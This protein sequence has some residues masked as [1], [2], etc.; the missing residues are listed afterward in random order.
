MKVGLIGRIRIVII[1]FRVVGFPDNHD[2]VVIARH[3]GSALNVLDVGVD[4][5]FVRRAHERHR[6]AK[7]V[8]TTD[9]DIGAVSLNL[10]GNPND[11]VFAGILI[12]GDLRRILTV[13]RRLIDE[14]DFRSRRVVAAVVIGGGDDLLVDIIG[15][16]LRV[17][18]LPDADVI[19]AV[20]RADGGDVEFLDGVTVDLALDLE[21][22]ALRVAV[23]VVEASVQ[24][25][26]LRVAVLRTLNPSDQDKTGFLVDRDVDVPATHTLRTGDLNLRLLSLSARIEAS[27]DAV[28]SFVAFAD[29]R[30]HE[31]S[32]LGK[33]NIGSHLV[34][35]GVRIDAHFDALLATVGVKLMHN[36]IGFDSIQSTVDHN[37]LI[38]AVRLGIARRG[39]RIVVVI[40]IIVARAGIPRSRGTVEFI[41]NLLF[42]DDNEAVGIGDDNRFTFAAIFAGKGFRIARRNVFAIADGRDA[43][44]EVDG[45][46][47]ARF[48]VVVAVKTILSA[49][50]G[51]L[52]GEGQDVGAV[53]QRV[54]EEDDEFVRICA[55]IGIR[56]RLE[57]QFGDFFVAQTLSAEIIFDLS[58]RVEAV[59]NIVD[60]SRRHVCAVKGQRPIVV[61]DNAL[62]VAVLEILIVEIAV[63]AVVHFVGNE[64]VVLDVFV[65]LRG[66]HVL[67]EGVDH[68]GRAVSGG[69]RHAIGVERNLLNFAFRVGVHGVGARDVRR[70]RI[71]GE[72]DRS[73]ADDGFDIFHRVREIG[74]DEDHVAV[75]VDR[76]A[77]ANLIAVLFRIEV[78]EFRHAELFAIF[79]DV[80]SR[81]VGNGRRGRRSGIV[82]AGRRRG[83][84]VD[85]FNFLRQLIATRED[86]KVVCKVGI[87]LACRILVAFVGDDDRAVFSKRDL[88]MNLIVR[89]IFVDLE[90]AGAG[91]VRSEG[92]A[93][94]RGRRSRRIVS[95]RRRAHR[96]G[97]GF[98]RQE[99]A[100]ED[101]AKT[102]VRTARLSVAVAVLVVTG[103]G[104]REGA[105]DAAGNG[106]PDLVA[107]LIEVAGDHS[108]RTVVTVI[109]TGSSIVRSIVRRDRRFRVDEEF[110]AQA[111][112]D[113]G[114]DP[115]DIRGNAD[116]DLEV[117]RSEGFVAV[118]IGTKGADTGDL[119][120]NEGR[121]TRIARRGDRFGVAQT[122]IADAVVITKI[123]VRISS[124]VEVVDQRVRIARLIEIRAGEFINV[125]SLVF[126]SRQAISHFVIRL[127]DVAG[128]A[129]TNESDRLSKFAGTGVEGITVKEGRSRRGESQNGEVDLVVGR[130]ARVSRMNCDRLHRNRVDAVRSLEGAVDRRVGNVDRNAI[131]VANDVRGGQN[132]ITVRQERTGPDR[133]IRRRARS[134]TGSGTRA[135]SS[136][137]AVSSHIA[138]CAADGDQ[139]DA[140][141]TLTGVDFVLFDRIGRNDLR[142]G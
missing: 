128:K 54:L 41:E 2:A 43:D 142:G 83:R 47:T 92:K 101:A 114:I 48:A 131:V 116:V 115:V 81:V 57:I 130:S 78:I 82:I 37:R 134:S 80:V 7:G 26:G 109:I 22:R 30:H 107:L 74:P 58:R 67:A 139:A 34:P 94:V 88:R 133:K 118:E 140:I 59:E 19:H 38:V 63:N 120:V 13:R 100:H 10:V 56:D 104:D 86:T 117:S 96:G 108:R 55:I 46:G 49:R 91:D 110:V 85:F 73:H 136:T 137:R 121:G 141:V 40:V 77:S 95:R 125:L 70:S 21:R 93:V 8:E 132:M 39:R 129:V 105:V 16:I 68:R 15:A 14:R 20:A 90:D 99:D 44:V 33:R 61:I 17:I 50:V 60:I 12:R 29:P 138:R 123:V 25:V 102:V 6:I 51:Y 3:V 23:K 18:H 113:D 31:A 28:E 11:V 84:V 53:G 89:G 76:D 62:N 87:F 98:G 65:H 122:E 126:R 1:F 5:D 27:A 45:E 36:D 69:E 75:G 66:E 71:L 106:R 112:Q 72:R 4:K 103:P 97:V 32:A 79:N 9:V 124:V 127:L 52:I 42:G 64:R 119:T 35:I 135:R 24:F 111:A